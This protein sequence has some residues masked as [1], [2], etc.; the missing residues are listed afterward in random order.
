VSR[1][2]PDFATITDPLRILTHKNT[3]WK[4]ETTEIK[5]FNTLKDKL[6]TSAM[7]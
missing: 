4:W 5:A 7:T 2:I 6:T 3:Q 1:F